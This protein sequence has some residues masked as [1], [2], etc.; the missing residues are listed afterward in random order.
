[1]SAVPPMPVRVEVP[2]QPAR[3]YEVVIEPGLLARL[4]NLVAT[5]APASRYAVLA[6]GNV[7]AAYGEPL[8]EALRGFGLD[9]QL[10]ILPPG[11]AHK[12]RTTWA[13]VT[14]E[15][16]GGG[17][18]R[19]SCI[20]AV[21]GGVAGDLAGFIAATFMRGIKF[22]Q[23]PTSLLAMVDAS[24]GGKTGVDTPAGKN[25]VGAFH[26]PQLV[27][28]DPE[29]LAT[30]PELELRAGLA[31]TV[32]HGAIADADYLQWIGNAAPALFRR[33]P[34][35]LGHL[36]RRSVE[37]K[38][39]F[40]SADV[41][42]AGARESLNFGHTIG[43]AIEALSGY[44]LPHGYAVAIGMVTEAAIGEAAGVTETST[45]ERLRDVLGRM[46]LPTTLPPDSRPGAILERCRLDK[47]A[48]VGRIR[49]TLIARPGQVA[50]GRGGEFA[51]AIDDRTVLGVL[52]RDS[53]ARVVGDLP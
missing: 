23:V 50:R 9:A 7:A 34:Q 42:E 33:E 39:A 51:L 36:V 46:G 12:D 52:E 14:D 11:E 48:R 18:G 8:S 47:K 2:V 22:I 53:L 31:E 44:A 24:I 6:D 16:L 37:I 29:V 45:A 15:L 21:G 25:L 4:P 43:H 28:V 1:M 27:A 17:F 41:H 19:D 30:L 38:A 49:Y 5:V 40:V 13:A 20:L 10:L 35:A 3:S 26:Q 32:K